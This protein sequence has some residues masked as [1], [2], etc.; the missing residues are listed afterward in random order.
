[1]IRLSD[2]SVVTPSG[3]V[4]KSETSRSA[5]RAISFRC[6]TIKIVARGEGV[7]EDLQRDIA[8]ELRVGGAIDLAH[9]AL[10]D[11]GGDVVMAETGTDG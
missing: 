1:M 9:A 3:V 11:E 10:A 2:S 4:G 6:P 8:A 5:P 7:G